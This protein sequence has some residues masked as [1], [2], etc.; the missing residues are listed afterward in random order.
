MKNPHVSIE[1]GSRYH[2]K[3]Y[4]SEGIM[5][6][7]LTA[8]AMLKGSA[9]RLFMAIAVR[10]IHPC[11]Q[12]F[13]ERELGWNRGTIRKGM[14]ELATGI[15]CL[16]GFSL[17]GRRSSEK[18]LPNL[19][20]DIYDIVDPGAHVDATLRTQRLYI[21]MTASQVRKQLIEQKNYKEEE[22][23]KRRTIN[24]ILNRMGYRLRKVKKNKPLKKI[25]QTDAIFETLHRVN[26]EADESE[27]VLRIS[28]DAKA[29][30]KLG[31]FS[32]GGRS[33]VEVNASD[34]DFGNGA[35][36]TP[37]NI[38]LPKHD[39][40][41]ISFAE[42]K[43]TSDYIWDR[44]EELWPEWVE[45]HRPTTLLINQDNGPENSSRRTQGLGPNFAHLH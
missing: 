16:D 17:R 45:K 43:I 13:A 12:S 22:L 2:L 8:A 24:T 34:H 14:R 31:P 37:H 42:S 9:R 29:T 35:T 10:N 18:R 36:L 20:N 28:M 1:T 11:G 6:L 23:P 21:K 32:R 44:V 33:R 39:E 38:L 19:I 15:E 41:Y 30:V 5:S 26:R 7:L 27:D 4:F 3:D 25:P 40:L